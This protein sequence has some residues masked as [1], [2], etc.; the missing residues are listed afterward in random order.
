NL[1]GREYVVQG[2]TI[3]HEREVYAWADAP[4][5]EYP[6]PTGLLCALDEFANDRPISYPLTRI[7]NGLGSLVHVDNRPLKFTLQVPAEIAASLASQFTF[8]AE[9]VQEAIAK[10]VERT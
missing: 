5:C 4:D 8:S 3:D 6:L 9:E 7:V 1:L 10:E 2:L